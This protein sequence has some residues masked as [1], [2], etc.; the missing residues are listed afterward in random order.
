MKVKAVV[1]L[2]DGRQV[3]VVAEPE[4]LSYICFGGP[5]NPMALENLQVISIEAVEA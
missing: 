5:E 3:E 2:P 1:K 4:K